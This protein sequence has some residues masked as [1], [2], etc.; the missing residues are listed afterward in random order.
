MTD[1]RKVD[2]VEEMN[3]LHEIV[4]AAKAKL[5]KEAWDYLVGAAETE[6]T[7]RRNR[8]A[9]DSLGPSAPGP[10]GCL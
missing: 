6:T 10:H 2:S 4:A 8:L 3:T 9:L 7:S 1:A 5:T